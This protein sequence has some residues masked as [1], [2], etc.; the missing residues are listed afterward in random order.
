MCLRPVQ[1]SEKWKHVELSL[2]PYKALR[3]TYVLGGVDEV[4]QVLEDSAV[5]MAAVSA[6][7]YVAGIRCVGRGG[8]SRRGEQSTGNAR[9]W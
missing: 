4:Q 1:V 9:R 2:R 3:D 7:R 6:S 8:G 5:M